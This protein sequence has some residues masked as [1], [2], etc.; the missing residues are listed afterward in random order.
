MLGSDCA[1]R[2]IRNCAGPCCSLGSITPF[3]FASSRLSQELGSNPPRL[4]KEPRP[5]ESPPRL[6]KPPRDPPSPPR[7]LKPPRDP[8]SPPRPPKP[9]RPPE[10]PPEPGRCAAKCEV[11]DSERAKTAN[12]FILFMW[13]KHISGKRVPPSFKSWHKTRASVVYLLYPSR[14][15]RILVVEGANPDGIPWKCSLRTVFLH[16]PRTK[17]QHERCQPKSPFI[18]ILTSNHLPI[19]ASTHQTHTKKSA[20]TRGPIIIATIRAASCGQGVC[21][22]TRFPKKNKRPEIVNRGHQ[23]CRLFLELVCRLLK[24]NHKVKILPVRHLTAG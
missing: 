24:H 17:T 2:P 22:S 12:A 6:L 23:N 3:P 19:A 20:S 14:Q 1:I 5:P 11:N 7:L 8:P 15:N 4:P 10:S 9:P 13:I 21:L 16:Q 18:A